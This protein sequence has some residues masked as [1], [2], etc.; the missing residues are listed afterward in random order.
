MTARS[1]AALAAA[2]AGAACGVGPVAAFQPSL[3]PAWFA[4]TPATRPS[5]AARVAALRL[6][7]QTPGARARRGAALPPM[8]AE[9]GGETSHPPGTA[10]SPAE[11]GQSQPPPQG[12][13]ESAQEQGGETEEG[14]TNERQK[15]ETLREELE[16]AEDA[17]DA[18]ALREEEAASRKTSRKR[19]G[20]DTAAAA[21][22]AAAAAGSHDVASDG[23]VVTA[24]GSGVQ[25]AAGAASGGEPSA[26]APKGTINMTF[27]EWK[28]AFGEMIEPGLLKKIFDQLDS[29]KNGKVSVREFIN[30]LDG[31]HGGTWHPFAVKEVLPSDRLRMLDKISEMIRRKRQ[32]DEMSKRIG[33]GLVSRLKMYTWRDKEES[34]KYRRTIFTDEDWRRFRSD[35]TSIFHNLDTMFNSRIIQGLWME[36]GTVFMVALTVYAMNACILS[37][38]LQARC[39]KSWLP[40]ACVQREGGREGG[41]ERERERERE[42]CIHT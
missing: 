14:K 6:H 41:R 31:F 37:G 18:A 8:R 21:A 9:A 23:P 20:G 36:V 11:Q 24:D 33:W 42:R 3:R 22:A 30:G 16:A 39:P 19:T 32:E 17:A 35:G 34:R 12:D 29:D 25:A 27:E 1:T 15:L 38:I 2:L 26:P 40:V 7:G 4:N 10:A 28:V 5:A 13:E